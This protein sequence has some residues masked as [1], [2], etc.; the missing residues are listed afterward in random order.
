MHCAS[1]TG[2]AIMSR[3]K[4]T[5]AAC[6]VLMTSLSRS[7]MLVVNT[8]QSQL[9]LVADG[10]TVTTAESTGTATV[11]IT[12]ITLT[13]PSWIGHC[14]SLSYGLGTVGSGIVTD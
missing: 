6:N 3:V 14:P 1:A 11:D 7:V 2:S 4:D 13:V 10:E 12:I 9:G 5:I 8:L